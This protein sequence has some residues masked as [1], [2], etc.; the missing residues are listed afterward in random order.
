MGPDSGSKNGSAFRPKN[1]PGHRPQG[2]L[3]NALGYPWGCASELMSTTS[4]FLMFAPVFCA[5]P[6]HSSTFSALA[7]SLH[8]L[9][10]LPVQF[11]CPPCSFSSLAACH[12]CCA[13]CL[14]TL[15][16]A[17]VAF[18]PRIRIGVRAPHWDKPYAEQPSYAPFPPKTGAILRPYFWD[19]QF[20]QILPPYI[21]C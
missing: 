9:S 5:F 20:N 12:A 2:R 14:P 8:A 18:Q 17:S 16:F 4:V 11:D 7:F 3:R 10:A 21:D 1:G 6:A 15:L 19:P 13:P